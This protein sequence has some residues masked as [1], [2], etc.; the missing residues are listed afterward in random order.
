VHV[1]IPHWLQP[2]ELGGSLGPSHTKPFAN[3]GILGAAWWRFAPGL[4]LTSSV[5]V[6]I[7]VFDAHASFPFVKICLSLLYSQIRVANSRLRGL[8]STL[9]LPLPLVCVRNNPTLVVALRIG[10]F[11]KPFTHQTTFQWRKPL[12]RL[13]GVCSWSPTNIW[14][15]CRDCGVSSPCHDSYFEAF[16]FLTAFPNN[17]GMF[18]FA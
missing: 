13:V 15:W 8:H 3:G 16:P 14:C 2:W 10:W 9:I 1:I 7:V 11:I 4:L 6:V 17:G 18:P 5:S 12:G